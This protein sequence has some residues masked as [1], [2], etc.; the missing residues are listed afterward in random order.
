MQLFSQC[1]GKQD[2]RLSKMHPTCSCAT[3]LCA[4]P[5][6]VGPHGERS[7]LPTEDRD[8]DTPYR[9]WNNPS[10]KAWSG[11]SGGD[12]CNAAKGLQALAKQRRLISLLNQHVGLLSATVRT[13]E[14]VASGGGKWM[15]VHKIC[16]FQTLNASEVLKLVVHCGSVVVGFQS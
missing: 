15:D 11:S 1:C 9:T 2:Q 4:L 12:A 10:S 14:V 3:P 7:R 8:S 5:S 13:A 16:L 6:C